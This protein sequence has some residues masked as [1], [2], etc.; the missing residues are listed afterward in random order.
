MHANIG[1]LNADYRYSHVVMFYEY[2]VLRHN[3]KKKNPCDRTRNRKHFNVDLLF[4]KTRQP[5]QPH[6]KTLFRN[7]F[8]CHVSYK[9]QLDRSYSEKKLPPS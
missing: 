5:L 8:K 6:C 9:S 7:T 2:L 3:L 4:L 1:M